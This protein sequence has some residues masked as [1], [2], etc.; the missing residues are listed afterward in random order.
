MHPKASQVRGVTLRSVR[1]SC[2]TINFGQISKA[3]R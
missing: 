1:L 3:R 2:E